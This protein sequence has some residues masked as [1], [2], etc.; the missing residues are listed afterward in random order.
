MKKNNISNKKSNAIKLESKYISLIN[1]LSYSIKELYLNLTKIIKAL[2]ANILEQNNYIFISKCLINEINNKNFMHEKYKN[3]YKNIEGINITDKFIINNISNLE[4]SST[5][6][7]RKSKIIFKKMKELENSKIKIIS[8]R[9]IN[10][11]NDL[12]SA[13]K[14]NNNLL[15]SSEENILDQGSFI[16]KTNK[17]KSN[18]DIKNIYKNYDNIKNIYSKKPKLN[19]YEINTG[20]TI[21]LSKKLLTGKNKKRF[22]NHSQDEIITDLTNDNIRKKKFNLDTIPYKNNSCSKDKIISISNINSAKKVRNN[23]NVISPRYNKISNSYNKKGKFKRIQ[24]DSIN[25]RKININNIIEFI[26][27]I[28]DYFYL[29]KIS[30]NNIINEPNQIDQ[31]NEIEIKLKQCLIKLNYSIFILNDFFKE[32]AQLKR[33]LNYILNVN[34]TIEPKLKSL[35]SKY[36]KKNDNILFRNDN[37]GYTFEKNRDK[38]INTKELDYI[39]LIKKLRNDNNNLAN[40]NQKIISQNKLLLNQISLVKKSEINNLTN[41]DEEDFDKNNNNRITELIQENKEYKTQINNL[42]KDNDKL[43][44]IINK[45][46][47]N[48]NRQNSS[49]FL[50]NSQISNIINYN[51]DVNNNSY[52]N[53]NKTESE[54]IK[55]ILEENKKLKNQLKEKEGDSDIKN[56]KEENQNLKDKCK[57]F[58]NSINE[59]DSIIKTLNN[60]LDSLK[61]ELEEKENN[62]TNLSKDLEKAKFNNEIEIKKFESLIQEVNKEN[63]K[64]KDDETDKANKINEQ[65]KMNKQLENLNKNLE[66][67]KNDILEKLEQQKKEIS[68]LESII[69]ALNVKIK[70]FEKIE[71]REIINIDNDNI[72]NDSKRLSTPSFKSPD[73]DIDEIKKLKKANQIL[74]NKLAIYESIIKNNKTNEKHINN[75]KKQINDQE[76]NY[77]LTLSS[78]KIK[79]L[80]CSEEYTIL[81]DVSFNQL[82]WYLLKSK[83]SEEEDNDMDSYENLNWVPITDIIDFEKFQY[84]ESEKDSEF[85]NLIK[86][87]EEKEKIIGKL[88]YKIEKLEK[89][90]ENNFQIQNLNNNDLKE[91]KIKSED[92]LIPIQKYDN[93]LQKLNKM[94]ANFE[95][96]QNENIELIKFKKMYFD[97][98]DNNPIN[99]INIGNLEDEK[100]KEDNS[101][102][103]DEIDYYKKKSEELQMLLSVLKEGIKNILKKV[104][105]PKKEKGEIKQILK[106]FEFSKEETSRIL[107]DK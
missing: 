102:S 61:S 62:C 71:N 107:G 21:Y 97:L 11:H 48:D 13:T 38:L 103:S 14:I 51:T 80:Y 55:N 98:N 34:E 6:F 24:T 23:E 37:F 16:S 76:N 18:A 31:E 104:V 53:K 49:Y 105:I 92:N 67:D 4:D 7:F 73:E 9:N 78:V 72:E 85:V 5:Q 41:F 77:I 101:N 65:I 87:L 30:Q 95:K 84:E 83:N 64:L 8:H 19:K 50:N 45:I 20:D 86:K 26:E 93:L 28:I 2:K 39:K 10:F 60:N 1:S 25:D 106:L 74:F 100:K 82:K 27:N 43:C 12:N 35:I 70:L 75:T 89:E 3:L 47:N 99:K 88:S 90:P 56:L 94:E 81:S 54:N 46:N 59:K 96:L 33:Q 44:K 15:F 58:L 32:K 63:Q 68:Q 66:K 29:L 79:K 17:I 40:I 57:S 52:L 69:N 22:L 36:N 91:G 42:K